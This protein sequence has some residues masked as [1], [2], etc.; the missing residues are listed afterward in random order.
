M[1]DMDLIAGALTAVIGARDKN[2]PSPQAALPN[3]QCGRIVRGLILQGNA[4]M[5]NGLQ[6]SSFVFRPRVDVF[7]DWKPSGVQSWLMEVLFIGQDSRWRI[8]VAIQYL[9]KNTCVALYIAEDMHKLGN[10]R[11][12]D[13]DE[14]DLHK[15]KTAIDYPFRLYV[16]NAWGLDMEAHA[17]RLQLQYLILYVFLCREKLQ[18]KGA[19]VDRMFREEN[20][21]GDTGVIATLGRALE[22]LDAAAPRTI[23]DK[24][25]TAAPGRRVQESE[26]II[27]A[28]AD[29]DADEAALS[30]H[31]EG[32]SAQPEGELPNQIQDETLVRQS[33][34]ANASMRTSPTATDSLVIGSPVNAF[35]GMGDQTTSKTNGSGIPTNV[36]NDGIFPRVSIA[37]AP[38]PGQLQAQEHQYGVRPDLPAGIPIFGPLVESLEVPQ[39]STSQRGPRFDISAATFSNQSSMGS[40]DIRSHQD[41]PPS[42]SM[43]LGVTNI[44]T[45]MRPPPAPQAPMSG[46]S[47]R[48]AEDDPVFMHA[49]KMYAGRK[50]AVAGNKEFSIGSKALSAHLNQ[51]SPEELR[52]KVVSLQW[53]CLEVG[54]MD[55]N[56]ED[57]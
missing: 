19:M 5:A 7:G 30:P 40:T 6:T 46:R 43:F 29:I 15:Y 50:K 44:P 32:D 48:K 39:A 25:W 16:R 36:T 42:S 18:T 38:T 23:G 55:I 1:R 17:Q 33:E 8:W 57:Q 13:V 20:L 41:H 35:H 10:Q 47:K 31:E 3:S 22:V 11:F 53:E 21:D 28:A 34:S 9:P 45:S 14:H 12:T 24:M 2:Q 37:I 52:E 26:G 49:A 27:R 51:L 54:D 56:L 4:S